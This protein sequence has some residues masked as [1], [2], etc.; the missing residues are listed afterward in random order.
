MDEYVTRGGQPIVTSSKRVF[1]RWNEM[2]YGVWRAKDGR[3]VLFNRFY[4]P[5][6]ARAASGASPE[7][8]A[9]DQRNIGKSV[10]FYNDGHSDA[11][12]VRRAAAVMTEWGLPS[13]VAPRRRRASA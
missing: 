2:P 8:A 5:I 3:E 7:P 9:L 6:W 13:P 12:K 1:T 11:E 10:W 4:E